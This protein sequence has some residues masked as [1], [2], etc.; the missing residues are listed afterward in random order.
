M[1]DVK[2]AVLKIHCYFV[3]VSTYKNIREII[4]KLNLMKFSRNFQ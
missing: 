2:I 1:F 4:N 3:K